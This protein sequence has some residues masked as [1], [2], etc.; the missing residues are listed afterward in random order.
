MKT[1]KEW[2]DE[3]RGWATP[4]GRRIRTPEGFEHTSQAS[5][6]LDRDFPNWKWWDNKNFQEGGAC[7]GCRALQSKNWVRVVAHG[8]NGI[9]SCWTLNSITKSILIE[10]LNELPPDAD[11]N[12]DI[13]K[14][15]RNIRTTAEQLLN[16]LN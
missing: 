11:V 1:F 3:F 6:I 4:D 10:L 12:L 13:L 2:L 9:Y 5:D 8:R 7:M 15:Y 16:R 14:R